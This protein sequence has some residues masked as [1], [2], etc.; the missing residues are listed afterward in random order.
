MNHKFEYLYNV[1]LSKIEYLYLRYIYKYDLFVH[2]YGPGK[3]YAS[4]HVELPDTY[5]VEQ[6]DVLTRKLTDRVYRETGVIMT[7]IGVYSHNTDANA[8]TV[9]RE[10]TEIVMAHEWALGIHGFHLDEEKKIIRFDVVMS[11]DIPHIEGI[12]IITGEIKK[13]YPD[14]NPVIIADIDITD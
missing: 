2:D 3:A 4:V 1:F 11:F 10:I 7:G 8:E 14:Y 5:N 12:R 9:R 13:K 6:V